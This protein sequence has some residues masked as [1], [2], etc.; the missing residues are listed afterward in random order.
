[1]QSNTSYLYEYEHHKRLRNAGF[2]KFHASSDLYLIRLHIKS[3]VLGSG[4]AWNLHAFSTA[5]GICT[6]YPLDTVIS[7]HQSLHLQIYLSAEHLPATVTLSQIDGLWLSGDSSH[8][9]V[10]SWHQI[11]IP[12]E[13]VLFST[14]P[15]DSCEEAPGSDSAA[16]SQPLSAASETVEITSSEAETSLSDVC[17]ASENLSRKTCAVP[18]FLIKFL[19][20]LLRLNLRLRLAAKSPGRI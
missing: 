7:D 17:E 11:V 18:A 8:Y 3:P 9:F 20:R 16:N 19:P 12:S 10:A 5:S 2:L 14:E 6:L 1:M 13:H 4:I 15:E